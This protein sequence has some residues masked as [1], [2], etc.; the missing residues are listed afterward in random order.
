MDRKDYVILL[1]AGIG[2]VVVG[3]TIGVMIAA[4]WVWAFRAMGG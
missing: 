1:L 3:A 4:S 2:A